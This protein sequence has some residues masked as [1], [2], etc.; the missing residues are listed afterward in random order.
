MAGEQKASYHDG[1]HGCTHLCWQGPND[2]IP[3]WYAHLPLSSCLFPI[4]SK[5]CPGPSLCQDRLL[6]LSPVPWRPEDL[7]LVPQN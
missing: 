7:M 5:P 3:T 6:P 4:H 2:G 1:V